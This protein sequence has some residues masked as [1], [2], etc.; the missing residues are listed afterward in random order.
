M[1]DTPAHNISAASSGRD[2][3]GAC[4]GKGASANHSRNLEALI[5][6]KVG[7]QID[8]ALRECDA[9]GDSDQDFNHEFG[10]QDLRDLDAGKPKYP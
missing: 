8:D 2:Y 5:R 6:M 10:E 7:D 3:D 1:V 4:S 9:D